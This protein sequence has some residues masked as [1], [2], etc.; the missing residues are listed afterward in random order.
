MCVCVCVCVYLC[1]YIHTYPCISTYV[2]VNIFYTYI[3]IYIYIH[4]LA[5]SDL[6]KEVV[7]LETGQEFCKM[8]VTDLGGKWAGLLDFCYLVC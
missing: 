4:S 8:H 1:I 5:N 3:Q 2:Q 7:G 6:G